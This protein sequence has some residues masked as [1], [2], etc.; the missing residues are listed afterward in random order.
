[1]TETKLE[2]V[3][4]TEKAELFCHYT[5]QTVQQPCYVE[6][7]CCSGTLTA[8]Y[9]AEIGNGVPFSVYH[10]HD[11]R[12][13]IP[14]LA[15]EDANALLEGLAPLAQRVLD[16]Y[17]SGWD[18]NNIVATFTDDAK[19]AIDEIEHLCTNAFGDVLTGF[20]ADSWLEGSDAM[21][22]ADTTDEQIDTI[23]QSLADKALEDGYVLLDTVAYLREQRDDMRD[24]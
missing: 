3:P 17:D 16:G 23:A 12:W 13:G 8:N 9:N 5:R 1:M 10:G 20:D 19:A 22:N 15:A 11:Q 21:V 7:D 18:G 2:I 14:C 24:G 6:L 4:L